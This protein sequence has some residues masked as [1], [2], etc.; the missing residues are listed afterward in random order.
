MQ[1]GVGGG[2]QVAKGLVGKGI[3]VQ[4]KLSRL[5]VAELAAFEHILVPTV[6]DIFMP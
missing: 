2:F 5:V 6:M 1:V 3:Y 4:L